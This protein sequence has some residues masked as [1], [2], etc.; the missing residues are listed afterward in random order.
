MRAFACLL[1]AWLVVGCASSGEGSTAFTAV[2]RDRQQLF[3]HL[4]GEVAIVG[5]AQISRD[6]GA[7]VVLDDQTAVGVSELDP[8]PRKVRGKTVTVAGRLRRLSTPPDPNNPQ[9]T[10][11]ELFLLEGARWRAGDRPPEGVRTR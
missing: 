7:V 8:W 3:E 5:E 6:R 1:L 2:A 9:D 10:G 4:E 11:R